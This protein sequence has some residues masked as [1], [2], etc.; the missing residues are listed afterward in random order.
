MPLPHLLCMT[1][2]ASGGSQ[3][4]AV[5]PADASTEMLFH[6]WSTPIPPWTNR[7]QKGQKL[8]LGSDWWDYKTILSL[9]QPRALCFIT[10]QYSCLVSTVLLIVEYLSSLW[11]H[12]IFHFFY[13]IHLAISNL[14][15]PLLSHLNSFDK[16]FHLLFLSLQLGPVEQKTFSN[17]TKSCIIL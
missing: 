1:C 3:V 14:I 16:M 2:T 10:M 13:H 5:S 4:L 11:T 15:S 7:L 6:C 9:S 12:V 17:Y 8:W